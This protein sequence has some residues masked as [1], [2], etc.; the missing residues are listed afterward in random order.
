MNY[1][2][3]TARPYGANSPFFHDNVL[4]MSG[5]ICENDSLKLESYIKQNKIFND[6]NIKV[7][8]SSGGG[9]FIEA[10]K[11]GEVIKKYGF[12]TYFSTE[13][14]SLYKKGDDNISQVEIDYH[15]YTTNDM[16]PL[17]GTVKLT[18]LD[19]FNL[20]YSAANFIFIAGKSR[21]M[22]DFESFSW[23]THK[24]SN[25]LDQC[26]LSGI[27]DVLYDVILYLIDSNVSLDF[28]K[29]F[30]KQSNFIHILSNKLIDLN[31]INTTNE[32]SIFLMSNFMGNNA[33]ELKLKNKFTESLMLIEKDNNG[34]R[35]SF[36]LDDEINDTINS[37]DICIGF[38]Y[39]ITNFLNWTRLSEDKIL[40]STNICNEEIE[41]IM[42]DDFQKNIEISLDGF[43]MSCIQHTFEYTI[44][45]KKTFERLLKTL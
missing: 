35:L 27:Q 11:I 23:G 40:V 25:S 7:Y 38:G 6:E 29:Y 37:E 44:K 12:D 33:L 28:L 9:D 42:N 22:S 19:Y 5:E 36:I 4:L 31:I 8:I 14:Y 41:K 10:L 30:L 3:C 15:Y 17:F 24:L 45:D 39:F 32:K 21:E 34:I 18:N 13:K 26:S 16:P 20:C 2:Y 1:I 43:P